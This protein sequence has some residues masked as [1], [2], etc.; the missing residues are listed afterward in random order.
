ML[1]AVVELFRR[2]RPLACM[3]SLLAAALGGAGRADPDPAGERRARQIAHVMAPVLLAYT[4]YLWLMGQASNRQIGAM[5]AARFANEDLAAALRRAR[6]DA[7]RKRYEAETANASKTAF[8]ANMSHE[9]R[10]PLNAILGFSDIIAHQSMGPDEID[11]YADYAADIHSS[12]AHLLSLI[13]DLL[14]VAK[15]ESGRMEIE[16]R[17]LDP[18]D[19]VDGVGRLMGRRAAQKRQSLTIDIRARYAAGAGRR[20]RLSPD[21]AQPSFQCREVHARRRPYRRHLRLASGGGL[22]VIV[23][24]DGPA[25]RRTS[26]RGCSSLSRRSTIGSTARPAAPGWGWRWSTA[27]CGCMAARI[28]TGKAVPGGGLTAA[29]YFPSTMPAERKPRPALEDSHQQLVKRRGAKLAGCRDWRLGDA[30]VGHFCPSEQAGRERRSRAEGPARPGRAVGAGDPADRR[31][32]GRWPWPFFAPDRWVFWADRPLTITLYLPLIVLAAMIGGHGDDRCCIR[33]RPGAIRIA[34]LARWYRRISAACSLRSAPPGAPMPWLLWDHGNPVNHL[35]LAA[36]SLAVVSALVL[37]RGSNMT[38]VRL[39]LA[40]ISLMTTARFAGGDTA[41]D[42]VIAVAVALVGPADVVDRPAAGDAACT[43]TPGCASRSRIWRAS[44][45]R[46]ATRRCSKR[47]EAETANASKTAFLANMSHEL[48]TPLNA[49]L[50][51]SEIIAQEC[52][53]PVGSRRYKDYAGDIHSSGAHLLV[54]D[55]RSARRR[56]DRGRPDG[57]L[58]PSAGRPPHLRHRARSWSASRRAR[59][60]RCSTIEVE[61]SCSAAVR[62]RACPQ[63]DPD[64]PGFQRGQVHARRRAHRGGG[65]RGA[66][67]RLPDHGARQWPRHSAREAGQDLHALQPGGQSL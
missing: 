21:A 64:Q 46:P 43:R 5:I 61:P 57:D 47:F 10:T 1:M 36:A 40:P 23:S 15:I 32:S 18:R 44:W 59:R 39:R 53:G 52:F 49:I 62:R 60:A 42:H 3:M 8:L 17:W 16:P 12:G 31:R 58:A 50:G 2:L 30:S 35:F 29:L 11:R 45:R 55:Q 41:L 20:T 6:D 56:Q 19:A 26:W 14:D 4:I 34:I 65:Q 38:H 13:N 25:F 33:T 28:V 54:A 51:F 7:M 66:R 9:L 48:R 22:E 67:W 24:D 37:A 63:A 27:W